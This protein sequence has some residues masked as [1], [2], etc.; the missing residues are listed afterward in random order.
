MRLRELTPAGLA[1]ASSILDRV[2]NG[3]E[4][5]VPSTFL[6]NDEFSVELSPSITRPKKGE[7]PT[8][9]HLG[10]WLYRQLED[11]ISEREIYERSGMWSWLSFFLFDVICPDRNGDRKVAE[12][13]KYLLSKGNY[14][15]AYRHLVAGPYYIIRRYIDTP[16]VVKAALS[17]APDTPGEVYEQL[18]SRKEIVTSEAAIRVANQMYWDERRDQMRRG[19]AGSGAGSARRY[20]SVLMQYDVTYDLFAMT[21]RQLKAMLPR[22][23][24][25][26]LDD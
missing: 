22:E 16:S 19:A 8:R 13:P 1:E 14:R 24:E 7:L 4:R 6:E 5:T 10:L 18:A 3:E 17:N 11:A 21:D 9:W 15:K 25:K 23:F 12:D 26:F 20:A 2:R